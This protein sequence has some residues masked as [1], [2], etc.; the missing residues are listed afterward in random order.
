L[1]QS[2]ENIETIIFDFDGTIADTLELG[3]KISNELAGKFHFKKINSSEELDYLRNLST[4]DAIKAIGIS[5]LKLP[6]VAANFRKRLA[7]NIDKLNPI[8]GIPEVIKHLS[9]HYQLGILTSN[10]ENNVN[11][12]LRNHKLESFFSHLWTGINL[13]NKRNSI[14]KLIKKHQINVQ[15]TLLIGDE[16]RDIEA[17]KKCDLPI[18]SVTWG[19]HSSEI[20]KFYTPTYLIDKPS[21]L[22]ILLNTD[23]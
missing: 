9:R 19:F 12:F 1:K 3:R 2:L 4:Q 18:I 15:T 17:A 22:L 16:T 7:K 14:E 6:F 13:F 8:E 21:D 10:S 11:D 20:L 5:Y 23:G